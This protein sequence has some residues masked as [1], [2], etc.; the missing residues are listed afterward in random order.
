MDYEDFITD[1]GEY[2]DEDDY[3]YEPDAMDIAKENKMAI[4]KPFY[5][6]LNNLSLLCAETIQT[7]LSI[8]LPIGSRNPYSLVET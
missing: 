8:Q 7:E 4:E 6:A 1:Q 5:L 3:L 2:E